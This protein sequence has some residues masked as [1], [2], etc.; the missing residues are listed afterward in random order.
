[1][2]ELLVSSVH[3]IS[4]VDRRGLTLLH[5]A[6]EASNHDHLDLLLPKCCLNLNHSAPNYGTPLSVACRKEDWQAALRLASAGSQC[7]YHDVKAML[8][9]SKPLRPHLLQAL[10]R[11]PVLVESSKADTQNWIALLTRDVLA[12]CDQDS[13][14]QTLDR[15]SKWLPPWLKNGHNIAEA[16]KMHSKDLPA[17]CQPQACKILLANRTNP[18]AYINSAKTMTLL[19]H[20]IDQQLFDCAIEL[21]KAGADPN[22]TATQNQPPLDRVMIAAKHGSQEKRNAATA[23]NIQLRKMGA[24]QDKPE[25]ISDVAPVPTLDAASPSSTSDCSTTTEPSMFDTTPTSSF[26]TIFT[27]SFSHGCLTPGTPPSIDFNQNRFGFGSLHGAILEKNPYAVYTALSRGID[28]NIPNPVTNDFPVVL[29][30]ADDLPDIISILLSGYFEYIH[31][32]PSPNGTITATG[33]VDPNGADHSDLDWAGNRPTRDTANIQLPRDTLTYL[34][35]AALK[36]SI[37]CVKAFLEVD[38]KVNVRAHNCKTVLHLIASAQPQNYVEMTEMIV[39]RG[40][41]VFA[42]ERVHNLTPLHIAVYHKDA[43]LLEALLSSTA[44]R[45]GRRHA[46][47]DKRVYGC[48]L[49]PFD[50]AYRTGFL[51]G[52]DL[53]IKAHGSMR[54]E[55]RSPAL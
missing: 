45:M 23:L 1:M 14:L 25:P 33:I 22:V 26:V 21:L 12:N 9:S 51:R 32:P 4:H 46:E 7:T 27:S 30:L 19:D 2:F 18:N 16:L 5:Y 53:L 37:G 36:G 42:E 39:R 52:V 10:D 49:S 6:V 17:G 31:P 20:A 54:G 29:A 55:R 47:R 35:A 11:T 8:N 38:A 34:M 43:K 41:D 13:D 3:S 44:Y 24:K 40:A 28:P 48:G 15:L 50:L